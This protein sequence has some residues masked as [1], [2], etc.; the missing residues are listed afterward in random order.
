MEDIFHKA[1]II[2]EKRIK[3]DNNFNKVK[4]NSDTDLELIKKMKVELSKISG[5]VSLEF[6]KENYR[7]IYINLISSLDYYTT[8]I[9]IYGLINIARGKKKAGKS[10][11][12]LKIS[13]QVLDS[14]D[15]CFEDFTMRET[16]F[17]LIKSGIRDEVYRNS[18][19][20]WENIE[21]GLSYILSNQELNNIKTKLKLFDLKFINKLNGFV[22]RRNVMVHSFDRVIK[23]E[24]SNRNDLELANIENEINFY[25]DLIEQIILAIHSEILTCFK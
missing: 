5:T 12:D 11:Q 6:M 15:L 13:I 10:Y 20:K 17:E 23:I 24:S 8:E 7:C 22:E 4:Q 2:R 3:F 25:I 9:I 18:Y 1:G 19:Q 16:V 21:R 14:I